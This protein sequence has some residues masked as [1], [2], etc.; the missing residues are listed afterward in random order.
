MREYIDERIKYLKQIEM[1]EFNKQYE[2][3][4]GSLERFMARELSNNMNARRTELEM[5]LKNAH[6][7]TETT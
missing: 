1:E 4:Q 3:P 2:Y 6:N 7:E 5:L